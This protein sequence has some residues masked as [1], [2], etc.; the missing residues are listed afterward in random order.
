MEG[1]KWTCVQCTFL[2]WP[3]STRCTMCRVPRAPKVKA[4]APKSSGSNDIIY[5]IGE[6]V[7]NFPAATSHASV[8]GQPQG[9][10][11]LRSTSPSEQ[12]QQQQLICDQSR[13]SPSAATSS[14][15]VASKWPC[16]ACTYLNW[17]RSLK[18]VQCLTPKNRRESPRSS[19]PASLVTSGCHA[20]SITSLHQQQ[21]NSTLGLE[22][23]R[24]SAASNNERNRCARI[25]PLNSIEPAHPGGNS[26]TA[27][28]RCTACTYENWPVSRICVLC[29]SKAPV[30]VQLMNNASNA[31]FRSNNR[32]SPSPPNVASAAAAAEDN[33]KRSLSPCIAVED[34]KSGG[35]GNNYDYE[36]KMRNFRRR[37]READWSWLTACMGVVEG[38]SNPVEAYLNGGGD[39]TRKLTNPEVGLL[40]RQGVYEIGHT[41]VHLAIR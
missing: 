14:G 40:N 37:M 22:Q 38:D 13:N 15:G 10:R 17:P 27:K 1:D 21:G 8:G 3:S 35:G 39:P 11:S 28:W 12:Q 24:I 29:G 6:T 19:P 33:S 9:P 20:A 5:R 23:L 34:N 32:D 4:V 2:N 31:G 30:S 41:L 18:C 16:P 36:R 25:S 26:Q 7:N